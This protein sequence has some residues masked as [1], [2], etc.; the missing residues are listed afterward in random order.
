MRHLP[1]PSSWP[2]IKVLVSDPLPHIPIPPPCSRIQLPNWRECRRNSSTLPYKEENKP[3][4][5]RDCVAG[6]YRPRIGRGNS[7]Y[8]VS[9]SLRN[10]CLIA[11]PY[12][13]LLPLIRRG[14]KAMAQKGGGGAKQATLGYVRDPQLSIGCVWL[15]LCQGWCI[16][17][18]FA[19]VFC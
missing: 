19:F 7:S 17:W 2:R 15:C 16:G 4:R 5:L 9:V 6:I 1:L 12:S 8:F 11:A 18:W 3:F 10:R 13:S 14:G